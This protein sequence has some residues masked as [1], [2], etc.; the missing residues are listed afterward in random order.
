[1]APLRAR[2]SAM[3][4]PY[5]FVRNEAPTIGVEL[6]L[7]LVDERTMALRSGIAD[8]LA[9]LPRGLQGAVTPELMQCYLEINTA[10]C[11][12]VAAIEKDLTGKLRAVQEAAG[13][14]GLRLFWSG[15][16]PFSHWRDQQITPNDRYYS[17]VDMLQDTARRLTTCGLHVHVGVD[18]G[19]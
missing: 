6:E 11:H 2:A 9:G 18:S 16:H 10:V 15:T 13:R 17:L 3:T 7:N 14:L 19:D 5:P 4:T 12:E 8:V 1:R